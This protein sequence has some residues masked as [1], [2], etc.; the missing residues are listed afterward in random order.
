[1]ARRTLAQNRGLAKTIR[2]SIGDRITTVCEGSLVPTAFLAGL[3]SVEESSLNEAATLFEKKIF[4]K[5]KKVRSGQR[6]DFNGVK[7]ADIAGASDGALRNL[8]TSFGL[9]QIL[10]LHVIATFKKTITVND[11]RDPAKH[12]TFAVQFIEKEGGTHLRD[13]EFEKVLRIHN[14]GKPNGVTTDP[15]YVPN[16]LEVMQAYEALGG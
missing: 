12:L 8:S 5:L 9:T 3:I 10:G 2:N 16:A 1:M 15:G 13:R 7:T 6:P 14:T 4:E 11:L